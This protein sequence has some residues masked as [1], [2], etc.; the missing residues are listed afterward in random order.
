MDSAMVGQKSVRIRVGLVEDDRHYR[1]YLESVLAASPRHDWVASAGTAAEVERWPLAPAPDVVLVDVGLP[2]RSGAAVVAELLGR[3]PEVLCI[4]LSASSDD[5]VVL[6]AIRRGAVGFLLKGATA[7]TIVAAIDDALAGGAPMSPS[8]ARK[9]L[10]AVRLSPA[11][12]PT[13]AKLLE[14]S[15]RELEVIEAVANGATDKEVADRLGLARSTVK[16]ILLSV[17]A[18]WRVRTRTEAAVTFVR[19][20]Q[21]RGGTHGKP[22]A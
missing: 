7:E 9:V 8:I 5:G 12:E 20:S 3:Y 19:A 21:I 4:M 22:R 13:D 14:L 10:S 16:N 15:T 1:L 18:K 2:D 17:Y 6:D 11:G